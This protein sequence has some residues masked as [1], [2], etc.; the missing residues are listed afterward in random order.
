[1]PIAYCLLPLVVSAM[2]H[3]IGHTGLNN[4]FLVEIHH[5]L[6]MRYNDVS[7]LENMHVATLFEM[8]RPKKGSIARA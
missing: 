4:P 7:P 1:M 5:E 6:A 8:C 3:D 2:A